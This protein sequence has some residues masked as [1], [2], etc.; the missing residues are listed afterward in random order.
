MNYSIKP[1]EKDI[2]EAKNVVK[3]VVETAAII[4]ENPELNI[5]LG[6]TGDQFIVD[7]LGGC[8]SFARS[9]KTLKIGFNTSNRAW[10][11]SLK[12][13]TSYGYGKCLFLDLRGSEP[14]NITFLWERILFEGFSHIFANE[15]LGNVEDLCPWSLEIDTD[16]QEEI[17]RAFSDNLEKDLEED[18]ENLPEKV[19]DG[20]TL[21]AASYL[22]CKELAK[23]YDIHEIPS[24]EK[25]RVV[26]AGER[27]FI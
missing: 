27:L 2:R 1:S 13:S 15:C 26:E 12:F 11:D 22:I 5:E 18:I 6:W 25:I 17:W 16:S 24:L 8:E 7:N 14:D 3:G 20:K 21:E 4:E 9:S 23:N 10:K 19:L